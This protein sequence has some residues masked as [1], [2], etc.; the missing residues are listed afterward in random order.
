MASKVP[1]VFY[2]SDIASDLLIANCNTCVATLK[3][4]GTFAD[5]CAGPAVFALAVLKAIG[6]ENCTSTNVIISD[7]SAGMLEAAKA[8]VAEAAPGRLNTQ[9]SIIDVQNIT[10]PSDSIDLVGCM[11]GFFVPDRMKAWSEVYRVCKPGGTAVIGTWK[12]AEFVN[13]LDDFLNFLG[14]VEPYKAHEMAFVCADSDAFRAELLS[15]GFEH[16]VIH[17]STNI[18]EMPLGAGDLTAIFEN[19]MIKTELAAYTR[20]VV[21]A[22]W[23][24]FI[25]QPTLKYEVDL[26]IG[27][28]R[29]KYT[30]N[31]AIATK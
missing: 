31:I 11:F 16:V 21:E 19:P 4:G 1:I 15:Q 28:M 3:S 2:F 22:A 12:H 23:A 7:F 5:L 18:F 26:E 25:R 6:L 27:K 30:A 10:L 17:E 24:E 14:R 29:V 13:I 9:F 20:D 8:A